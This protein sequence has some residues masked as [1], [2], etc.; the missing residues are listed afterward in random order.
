MDHRSVIALLREFVLDRLSG[1]HAGQTVIAT[2]RRP[3][4]YFYLFGTSG[5]IWRVEVRQLLADGASDADQQHVLAWLA[6]P[7]ADGRK[8]PPAARQTERERAK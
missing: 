6:S 4:A 8:L 5:G 1:N 2:G 7:G 3:V